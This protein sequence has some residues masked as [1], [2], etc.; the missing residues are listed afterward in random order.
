MIKIETAQVYRSTRSGRRFF[1]RK[2]ARIG[3]ARG[4]LNEIWPNYPAEYKDGQLVS[5][6]EGWRG[7][8]CHQAEQLLIE[9]VADRIIDEDLNGDELDQAFERCWEEA[10]RLDKALKE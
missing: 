5:P 7:A 1:S 10:E 2:S 6:H 3:E 4:L 8:L 9:L